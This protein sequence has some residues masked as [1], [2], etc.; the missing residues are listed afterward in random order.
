VCVHDDE[1]EKRSKDLESHNESVGVVPVDGF[2]YTS[3]SFS[4][5][6]FSLL[7]SI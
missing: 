1:N 3:L 2:E 6:F 4:I 7:Y 5:T